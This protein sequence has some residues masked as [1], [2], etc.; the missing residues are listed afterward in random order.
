MKKHPVTGK[1]V[2]DDTARVPLWRYVNPRQADWP[3]ADYVVG[4]PPFL[5]SKR[6]RECLGWGYA[7]CLLETWG[8]SVPGSADF[9]F[10]WWHKAA[11]LVRAGKVRQFGFITT[12][13]LT[14]ETGRAV[15][16][17]HL[18]AAKRPLNL[19]FAIPDHPWVDSSD[20][21]AVRIAM[22]VGSLGGGQGTLCQVAAEAETLNGEHEVSLT[23]A[24]GSISSRLRL[25]ARVSSAVRLKANSLLC[26]QGCKLVGAGFQVSPA[27]A[28]RFSRER[29]ANAMLLRSYWAGSD[30]TKKREP[31][32]VIDF[33]G[34]AR[35]E[36][37][38]QHPEL[39]QHLLDH[40]F[41]E[42]AQNRDQTFR[43]K[44]WLF[45][46]RRPELREALG[47]LTR[48][49]VTSEVAK[50]RAFMFLAWPHELIDGSI[51]ALALDDAHLF[52]VVS[53]RAHVC[54]ALATGGRMGVG[55]D[56]RYQAGPCFETFPFPDPDDATR[57]RIRSLGEQLDAHRKRQQ[58]LHP[59]LTLT[60]MYNVL[61]KLRAGGALT[62][63]EKVIHDQGLV[64]VLKQIHDDLDAAVFAA[65]QW[66]AT[67]SDE[68][69][70]E[71]L[72][73]LNHE[74][75][76]EEKRGHIRWLR[77]DFQCRDQG[78]RPVQSEMIAAGEAPSERAPNPP[79]AIRHPPSA[80]PKPLAAQVEAV[81]R[82]LSA[83]GGPVTAAEV[84]ARFQRAN[85]E[86]V[87][88]ILQTL[89]ALGKA[90]ETGG[91]RFQA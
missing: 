44:W 28:E 21:A 2:P 1:D 46:R 15:T 3:E 82:V 59:G 29:P 71:R 68:E 19:T 9:V 90:R 24:R 13:T 87:T 83:A 60:G 27:E 61:E 12:N 22:T 54:W 32:F 6:M 47:G 34:M 18:D 84:A 66:P 38:V 14:Q 64:S 4:N 65:Y 56:P 10:Y 41:P 58:A 8:E 7:S 77:P 86:R 25:G 17:P 70:L 20:G 62:A 16:E 26:W 48:Y 72:V 42:R 52:G 49:I 51:M 89:V 30:V 43:E 81:R 91:G 37:Q 40:V 78:Q 50:H 80:W 85:R 5:G 31:R 74:R 63:K 23:T 75:A 53:S 88:E 76:E 11:E 79:S 73:A 57:E 45:G 39:Y 36:A 55:N 67:L 69:I 33:T 35:G